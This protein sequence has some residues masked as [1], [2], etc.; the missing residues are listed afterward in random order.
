MIGIVEKHGQVVEGALYRYFLVQAE[1]KKLDVLVVTGT[2][3]Y[4]RVILKNSSHA[5]WKG[6]GRRFENI[7]EAIMGYK[8]ESV[9]HALGIIG[10]SCK[11][12]GGTVDEMQ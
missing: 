1:G 12:S 6:M 11:R 2:H 5:A 9:R 8:S 7:E 3:S 10:E 4:V